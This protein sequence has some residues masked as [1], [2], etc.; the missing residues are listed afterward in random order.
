MKDYVSNKQLYDAIM[1]VHRKMDEVVDSRIVPLEKWQS[2]VMGQLAI[3]GAVFVIAS[4]VLI[5]WVRERLKI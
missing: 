2:Q 1:D 4:N 3:I 5:D